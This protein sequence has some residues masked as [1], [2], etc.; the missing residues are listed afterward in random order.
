MILRHYLDIEKG[1]V[2]RALARYNGSLGR[3]EYPNAVLGLLES[4]WKWTPP[5]RPDRRGRPP[6]CRAFRAS[7][8]GPLHFGSLVAA[9]ASYADARATMA[10]GDSFEDDGA[11]FSVNSLRCTNPRYNVC[12]YGFV[13]DGAIVRQN[14]RSALYEQMPEQLRDKS[15]AVRLCLNAANG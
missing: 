14:R 1:D 6:I 12:S 10:V 3:F 4:R 8:T 9:M 2:V 15:S 11:T 7:P 13:H 5:R